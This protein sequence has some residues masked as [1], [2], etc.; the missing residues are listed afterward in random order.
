WPPGVELDLGNTRPLFFRTDTN[1]YPP[2]FSEIDFHAGRPRRAAP[3]V[4]SQVTAF[5]R[6]CLNPNIRKNASKTTSATI[7]ASTGKCGNCG[8]SVPLNPSLAYTSGFTSTT[9]C[10]IGKLPSALHG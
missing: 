3:T 9:F 2:S 6:N 7:T 8:T 10:S 4:R 5:F 1:L